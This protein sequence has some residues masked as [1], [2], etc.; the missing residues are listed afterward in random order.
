MELGLSDAELDII[1]GS[2]G[3]Y[4]SENFASFVLG[5]LDV[6][7]DAVWAKYLSDFETYNLSRITEIRQDCYDRYLAR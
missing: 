1:A 6:D 3:T 4:C 5:N 7:D 2:I